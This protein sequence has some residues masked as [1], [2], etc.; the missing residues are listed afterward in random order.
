MAFSY[1]RKLYDWVL[2]FAETPHGTWALFVLAVAESSF[3]PVPPDVLLM[4]LAVA[5]PTRAF[6]F[7]AICTVGSVLGG[8]IGYLLG[9]EFYEFVGKPIID[10]YGAAGK[11]QTVQAYYQEWD[12]V[13]VIVAGFTP[14]P[15]KVFTIA[16]GAFQI[17]FTT[18]ILASIIGRGGRFFLVAGLIWWLGPQIRQ[19]TEKYFNLLTVIFAVLLVG[20]FIIVKYVI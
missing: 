19:F 11:Y 3:F 17:D 16:A 13:A 9:L 8:A 12:A 6:R 10:F 18:F 2:A 7:A 4:A 15:Y 5:I 20:G 1:L 14:I